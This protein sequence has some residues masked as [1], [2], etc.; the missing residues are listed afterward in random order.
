MLGQGVATVWALFAP[1]QPVE[2]GP[3]GPGKEGTGI[4]WKLLPLT[5]V[6]WEEEGLPHPFWKQNLMG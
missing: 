1:I 4:L 2:T 3:P 6:V 5:P